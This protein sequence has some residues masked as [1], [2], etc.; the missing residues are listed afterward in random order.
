[1]RPP[2]GIQFDIEH[3]DFWAEEWG[4][5]PVSLEHAQEEAKRQLAEVPT[6][7]PVRSQHYLPATPLVTG[8]PIFLVRQTDI[9]Y[10]GL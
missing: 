10:A 7:I 5:R 3:N 1:M 9:T 4:P 6:L 2:Q 8:N